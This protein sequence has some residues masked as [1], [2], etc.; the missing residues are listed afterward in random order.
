VGPQY[1]KCFNWAPGDDPPFHESDFVG[2]G[3][4]HGIPGAVIG[5]MW[6]VVVGGGL[7]GPI[8]A[9]IGAIIGLLVGIWIATAS[10]IA[11]GA[12]R[13][14]NHR[15]VCLG[16]R[17]CAV[18]SVSTP[19]AIA[20]LG[21][22]DNDEFF[23][24]AVMPY[25]PDRV[26]GLPPMTIFDDGFQ[27]QELLRP[28]DDLL[29]GLGY[30]EAKGVRTHDMSRITFKWLHCE[31]EGDFWVRMRDHATALGLL[32][33]VATV[34]TVV[35]VFGGAAAGCAA[36]SF[37]GPLGCIIG[38]IIGAIIALLIVGGA[39][40]LAT[41]AAI[42]SLFEENQGDIEDANVGDEP[43]GALGNGDRVVVFGEHVFDGLHEGWHEIHAL[44]T[45]CTVGTF[46]TDDGTEASFYVEWD[47]DFGDED[48][49]PSHEFDPSLPD[50]TP[51]DMRAGLA[52]EPF[53]QRVTALR[54]RWCLLLSERHDDDVAEAQQE[55]THRWTIHP[56]VDGCAPPEP[57]V[58]R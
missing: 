31:A 13:W 56:A 12:D 11:D 46:K 47:P 14:L 17:R 25:A 20:D 10:A 4:D 1:T 54:D 42:D 44:L 36:L 30:F 52:S 51:E 22:F 38:A 29:T 57:D 9:V 19:P 15:L 39:S 33:G 2:L 45:I 7:F 3:L 37:L 5:I 34:A 24:L 43:L 6:G 35:S 32:A 55:L 49:P 16:G 8:G 28:R 21:G 48:V 26:P 53:R 23:D 58:P 18:G 27:G 50:L 40:A 41:E